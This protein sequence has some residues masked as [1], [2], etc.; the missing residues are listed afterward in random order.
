L[1]RVGTQHINFN[2]TCHG[3]VLFTLA[4]GAFGLAC[5][6]YGILAAAIDGHVTFHHAVREGDVLRACAVEVSKSKRVG[7]YRVEVKRERDDAVV[8]AFT[9]TAYITDKPNDQAI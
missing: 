3:G 9:G 8:S 6:S 2:G 1:L 5:N 4:D 7:V